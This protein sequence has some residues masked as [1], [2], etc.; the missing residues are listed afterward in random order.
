MTTLKT[1]AVT[2]ERNNPQPSQLRQVAH[3]VAVGAGRGKRIK[4]E[5]R[6]GCSFFMTVWTVQ[7]G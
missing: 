6:I 2:G 7:E 1:T 4:K 3:P 5:Q